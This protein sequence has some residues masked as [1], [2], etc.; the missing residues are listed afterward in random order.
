MHGVILD[1]ETFDLGDVD[2]SALLQSLDSWDS[3]PRSSAAQVKRRLAQA[4]V[5]VT[6]KV[7]LDAGKLSALP[8]LQL[9][10]VAA[11]GVNNVDLE[12]A[13]AHGIMVCNAR[14][15]STPAV[16]QHTIGLMLALT[17]SLPQ[18][19]E[20]VR[21]GH[22][23]RSSSFC[24]LDYPIHELSG[25]TL[26][27]VG[28]GAL[29][30]GV[31]RAARALGMRVL[32]CNRPGAPHKKGRVPLAELL[33]QVD[34]LSLHC[35]LTEHTRG[36]IDGAALGAMKPDAL[37]INTARGG[38]V[39]ESALATA[40]LKGVIGG[41][42]MDCLAEEPP[43]AAN[44]LLNKNIPN[45]LVTPHSAWGSR[46]TRQRLAEQVADIISGWRAGAPRNQVTG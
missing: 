6:N 19:L 40:L 38:I 20:A 24:L 22:W 28:Y 8:R 17:T 29:G 27:I 16:V 33:P 43:P 32:L 15:Y 9:I 7:V 46:E 5:A 10:V 41:A 42:A 44:P 13:Y 23:S 3:Y 34:V 31:A 39:D 25:R 35:P 36:L 21:A 11:T 1:R 4:E 45:L 37:L 2:C 30:K 12:A 14:N 18:Y 26:G